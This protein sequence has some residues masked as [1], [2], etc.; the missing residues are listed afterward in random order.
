MSDHKQVISSQLRPRDRPLASHAWSC[1]GPRGALPE[2]DAPDLRRPGAITVSNSAISRR[3]QQRGQIIDA[4]S[5]RKS[6]RPD[7]TWC[8]EHGVQPLAPTGP[9]STPS[10]KSS[11]SALDRRWASRH[12]HR[13]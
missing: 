12:H 11:T 5:V 3:G 9:T 1:P 10:P 4:L 8:G 2:G 13:H 6:E 7:L